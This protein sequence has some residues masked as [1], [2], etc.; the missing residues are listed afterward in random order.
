MARKLLAECLEQEHWLCPSAHDA[1]DV[2]MRTMLTTLLWLSPQRKGQMILM[3][4][5]I[6]EMFAQQDINHLTELFLSAS[7]AGSLG[8]SAKAWT[9]NIRECADELVLVYGVNG[10]VGSF[11]QEASLF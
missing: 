7:L 9:M 11:L 2:L 5:Q 4:R 8:H 1:D 6:W 10:L 3:L